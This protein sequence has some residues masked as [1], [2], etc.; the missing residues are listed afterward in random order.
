[1]PDCRIKPRNVSRVRSFLH[2]L[3]SFSY[4]DIS[5]DSYFVVFDGFCSSLRLVL[6]VLLAAFRHLAP[7]AG[8]FAGQGS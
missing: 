3:C 8:G 4:Y 5:S 6:F 7:M 1:M 2:V